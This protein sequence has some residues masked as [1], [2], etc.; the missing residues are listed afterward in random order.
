M[1]NREQKYES[2]SVRHTNIPVIDEGHDKLLEVYNHVKTLK[3]KEASKNDLAEVFFALSYFF[4][5]HLIKEE[6]FLKSKGYPNFENHKACHA[7]F[8]K[9]IENLKDNYDKDIK[10]TLME[11]DIF[12]ASWINT[13]TQ[14][15]TKEVVE[16]LNRKK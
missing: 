9:G 14:N 4:E 11:L 10:C 3:S 2:E 6:L 7:N 8:I 1:G 13:H 12:I 5:D 16:F 15:Y